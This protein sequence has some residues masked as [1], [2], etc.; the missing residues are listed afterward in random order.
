MKNKLI[1][2]KSLENAKINLNE[3]QYSKD[4]IV[5]YD[6]R[7]LFAYD[8]DNLNFGDNYK[9]DLIWSAKG[10][11]NKNSGINLYYDKKIKSY[12]IKCFIENTVAG[13]KPYEKI[14]STKYLYHSITT[15]KYFEEESIFNNPNYINV[16]EYIMGKYGVF[17][18]LDVKTPY[19]LIYNKK[20]IDELSEKYKKIF[21][22]KFIEY[23]VEY[24]MTK[25]DPK[26]IPIFN[27]NDETTNYVRSNLKCLNDIP[28]FFKFGYD[29]VSKFSQTK[30]SL[31]F[32]EHI[33][34]DKRDKS[35]KLSN[36]VLYMDNYSNY[37]DDLNKHKAMKNALYNFVVNITR[38]FDDYTYGN[39][40]DKVYYAI[41]Q[42]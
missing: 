32:P 14:D 17:P 2:N 20:K 42:F 18:L 37:G 8:A 3:L 23:T 39:Q 25:L 33:I 7:V 10:T 40:N 28:K 24:C 15:D 34:I 35:L 22:N 19:M 26:Y 30:N 21:D 31:L 36:A 9:R 13:V 38:L 11:F 12:I 5:I 29:E 1:I 16:L 41:Y 6:N 4:N 27:L